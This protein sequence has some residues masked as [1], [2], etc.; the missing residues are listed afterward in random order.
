MA[1][2]D[3]QLLSAA[4]SRRGSVGRQRRVDRAWQIEAL[5]V[6]QM[7]DSIPVTFNIPADVA[8]QG[9]YAMVA[10]ELTASYNSLPAN[11]FVYLTRVNTPM[12]LK[13]EYVQAK[14]DETFTFK[15]SGDGAVI[16]LPNTDVKSGQIVIGIGQ[17]PIVSFDT[18]KGISTPNAST[19]PHNIFGL[20]EYSI[21][22]H[23]LD[24]DLSEIDQ[25][26]FPFTITTT[27]AAPIPA[28]D[29]VGITID[30][31]KLFELYPQYIASQGG[32]AAPFLQS[33][34]QGEPYRITSPQNV[35]PTDTPTQIQSANQLSPGGHLT[36][37]T[38]YYYWITAKNVHDP[39]HP[40]QYG[41][42]APSN[43]VRAVPTNIS[44]KSGLVP[45]ATVTL[46][47]DEFPEATGYNIYRAE[48]TDDLG[49]S[50][51]IGSTDKKTL[52]FQDD[53]TSTHTSKTPPP[54]LHLPL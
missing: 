7:L 16:D 22:S 38:N 32:V 33:Y 40:D 48:G 37:N 14:A 41:E 10:A 39:A 9:V 1:P 17:A 45:Y 28:N 49:K 24:I 25:V 42:T 6:R 2:R 26:G 46:S 34:T 11:T 43:V 15:L 36:L 5:E 13:W 21:D 52:T 18:N 54:P 30:R 35:P 44:T 50:M 23:G 12:G 53:N 27:P 8:S 3:I 29:G 47:W 20:F 31:E 4:R 19:N 51:L